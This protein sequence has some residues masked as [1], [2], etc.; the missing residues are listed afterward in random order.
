MAS[1]APLLSDWVSLGTVLALLFLAVALVA[2]SRLP[3]AV[4][5]LFYAA[6]GL[7]IVGSTARYRILWDFYD[8]SGDA[9]GYFGTGVR[10]ADQLRRF[11]FSPVME[12]L[13]S[14][15]AI[16]TSFLHLVS[17]FVVAV[18]GNSMFT[19]F[20]VFSLFALVG[21]VGFAVAY[22][23]SYPRASMTGYLAFIWLFPSLWYWPSSVGKEAVI[24]LGLGLA[25]MGYIGKDERVNWPLMALG[26]LIVFAVRPE[27]AGILLL[28]MIMAHWASFRGG[29]TFRRVLQGVVLLVVGMAGILH[30]METVG[31]EQ[32]D[33]EGIVDYAEGNKARD[34]NRGSLVDPVSVDVK[35]LPVAAFNVLFRPL[36]WEARNIMVVFSSLEILAVWGLILWRRR[37]FARSLRNWRSD[38][39]LTFSILF[40]LMYSVA[41]GLMLV[42]LG[43][44]A[45][46]RIFLFPFLFLLPEARLDT[47][48]PKTRRPRRVAPRRTREHERRLA[49]TPS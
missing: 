15:D 36:P 38:R 5:L 47:G 35:G 1:N 24:L 7:R 16:G 46:Q 45:R 25:V 20:L 40:I 14:G 13:E 48:A 11:D 41:L 31:I 34:I 30:S 26:T 10:E 22:H 2:R 9:R 32:V 18:I 4:K 6:V 8:G 33:V 49:G 43:I 3:R 21:L 19:E 37:D 28:A 23:R 39:F 44:I 12:W 27:I 17:T 42:N 29:W